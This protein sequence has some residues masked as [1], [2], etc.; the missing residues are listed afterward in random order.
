MATGEDEVSFGD[1]FRSPSRLRPCER[2]WAAW[3]LPSTSNSSITTLGATRFFFTSFGSRTTRPLL[4]G[5]HS[6]PSAVRQ[7]EGCIPPLHSSVGI[8]S[9]LPYVEQFTEL[10][11]PSAHA[12][13]SALLTL[14]IP[15]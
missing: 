15:A 2:I 3:S 9:P 8:P 5:N 13:N 4:V 1:A 6:R 11:F 7:P 12:F 10:V 14:I